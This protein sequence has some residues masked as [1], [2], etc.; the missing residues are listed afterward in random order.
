M[1]TSDSQ[2]P[3][4][5]IF[6]LDSDGIL[7]LLHGSAAPLTGWQ[8]GQPIHALGAGHDGLLEAVD[9]ALNGEMSMAA[10]RL[11]EQVYPL[12]LLPQPNGRP[13]KHGVIA[14]SYDPG[15]SELDRLTNRFISLITHRFRNPLTV[16]NTTS[17][18]LERYDTK[19]DAAKRREYFHKIRAQV[20]LMD[21]LIDQVVIVNGRSDHVFNP[22][23]LDLAVLAGLVVDDLRPQITATTPVLVNAEGD[24]HVTGDGKLLADMM[25]HLLVNAVKF[26][27]AGGEVHLRLW[28][29]ESTIGIAVQDHGLGIPAAEQAH[30]GQPFFRASNATFIQ[31]SGLGLR[32]ATLYAEQHGGSLGFVSAENSGSTFTVRLPITTS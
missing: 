9:S 30:I 21:E 15:H 3:H 20:S 13:G 26:S 24:V 23:S 5:L 16:I 32:I 22:E 2:S 28:R 4:D 11:G 6:S 18:L 29:E 19:L 14:L 27:P 8:P 1:M 17:Y 10:L 31:G 25:R 7:T 12:R